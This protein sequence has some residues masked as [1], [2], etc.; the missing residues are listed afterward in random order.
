MIS[1]RVDLTSASWN[2]FSS[3]IANS[4]VIP[5]FCPASAAGQLQFAHNLIP[6]IKIP[7]LHFLSLLMFLHKSWRSILDLHLYCFVTQNASCLYFGGKSTSHLS[8]SAVE[9]VELFYKLSVA[10]RHQ[11][12][13]AGCLASA[14]KLKM[15]VFLQQK[16]VQLQSQS[17]LHFKIVFPLQMHFL[18]WF[19]C[20]LTVLVPWP[21]QHRHAHRKSLRHIGG[22]DEYTATVHSVLIIQFILMLNIKTS[23]SYLSVVLCSWER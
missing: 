3:H 15:T 8:L 5:P 4:P 12:K 2:C 10:V 21:E 23:L 7:L 6:T 18:T 22:F 20:I 19:I 11:L 9:S 13:S 17:L 14:A 1:H 16:D